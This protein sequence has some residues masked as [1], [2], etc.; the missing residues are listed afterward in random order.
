MATFSAMTMN[1]SIF[2]IVYPEVRCK[3]SMCDNVTNSGINLFYWYMSLIHFFMFHILVFR[4]W[5]SSGHHP[6]MSNQE[7]L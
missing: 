3:T 1:Y 6:G 5:I 4:S 7:A 2:H